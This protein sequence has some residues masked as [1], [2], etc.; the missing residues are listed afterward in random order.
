MA[1]VR[2][3]VLSNDRLFR[4]GLLRI[5]A[6]EEAVAVVGHD[7][8]AVLR[9]APGAAPPDV[10]LVDS[11]TRGALDLCK[12]LK[13]EGGPPIVLLAADDGDDWGLGALAAG[14][15]GILSVSAGP[16]DLLKAVRLVH[17]GQVWARRHLM[18]EWMTHA[19]DSSAAP[20]AG[21]AIARRLSGREREIFRHAAAGLSNKELADR[22][23]ISQGTVKAH[24]TRIFQKLGLRGR[25]GLAAAYHGLTR[26]SPEAAPPG[27]PRAH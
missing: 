21:E 20:P 22:L 13:R 3:V 8:E 11:R 6:A 23:A 27:K 18:S 1:R 26:P 7:D 19:P 2:V 25:T 12:A 24:L 4:E 17:A 14:A 5:L 15:R 9:P 16:E 10:L